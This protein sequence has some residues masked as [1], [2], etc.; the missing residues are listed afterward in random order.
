MSEHPTSRVTLG[1][2]YEIARLNAGRSHLRSAARR[3][4]SY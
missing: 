3:R 1:S 4:E 2:G